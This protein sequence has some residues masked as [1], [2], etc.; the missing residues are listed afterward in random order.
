MNR[1]KKFYTLVVAGLMAYVNLGPRAAWA[2]LRAG[3]RT[4]TP[5]WSNH[6]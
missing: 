6:G 3:N 2:Y 4:I 1:L 5:D